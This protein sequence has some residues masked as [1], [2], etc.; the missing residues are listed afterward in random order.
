MLVPCTSTV[1]LCWSLGDRQTAA[2][3]SAVHTSDQTAAP[4]AAAATPPKAT[5]ASW[6]RP[7]AAAGPGTRRRLSGGAWQQRCAL[8]SPR[9]CRCPSA[10]SR[11]ATG[12]AHLQSHLPRL[13]QS[14]SIARSLLLPA[15]SGTPVMLPTLK[16]GG[17]APAFSD[18]WRTAAAGRRQA[19]CSGWPA[20]AGRPGRPRASWSP[21]PAQ[22]VASGQRPGTTA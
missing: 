16:H 12:P 5:P 11:C 8:S 22:R 2:A 15:S 19:G 7:A 6:P 4:T 9:V 20:S 18:T 10:W 17:S 21:T 14:R 3:A 13:M 1:Q